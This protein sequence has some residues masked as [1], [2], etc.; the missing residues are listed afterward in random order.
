MKQVLKIGKRD[1]WKTVSLVVLVAALGGGVPAFSK[2]ALG[3]FPPFTF[4]LIR[5]AIAAFILIPLTVVRKEKVEKRLLMKLVPVSLFAGANVIFFSLGV[6]RTTATISQLLYAAV[7]IIATLLS[8]PILK[9][10]IPRHK[11]IGVLIGFSGVAMIIFNPDIGGNFGTFA[12]NTLVLS[13]VVSYAA[14]TVLS[15]RM[16]R[17]ISPLAITT[18]MVLTTVCLQLPFIPAEAVAYHEL[19][20]KISPIGICGV[21]YV[22]I[23]G[24][25]LFFL[26]YQKVIK[27][28]NPVFASMIFYLQPVFAY[29]WSHVLLN[30]RLT[31]NV[32]AGGIVA[33]AGAGL[34]TRKEKPGTSRIGKVASV[35]R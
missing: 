33:L 32:V 6:T 21:V 25:A 17:H 3:V 20:D 7:P 28:A 19:V 15:K 26:L 27:M 31:I 23:C 10:T 24:T 11:I 9:A 22:G 12:G 13:A 5:F 2:V 18:T 8:I 29:A 34:V 30:E 16:Q 14:F 35:H 1:H 4:L